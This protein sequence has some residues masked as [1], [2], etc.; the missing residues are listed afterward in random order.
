MA[1]PA[2]NFINAVGRAAGAAPAAAQAQFAALNDGGRMR[3]LG[4]VHDA[5]HANVGAPRFASDFSALGSMT[6]TYYGHNKYA[7]IDGR[8]VV[9]KTEGQTFADVHHLQTAFIESVVCVLAEDDFVGQ[10]M[11]P[12]VPIDSIVKEISIRVT[13]YNPG[14]ALQQ[15]DLGV[16]TMLTERTDVITGG[17]KRHAIGQVNGLWYGMTEEAMRAAA[18]R[19]AQLHGSFT[20]ARLMRCYDEIYRHASPES[21]YSMFGIRYG[22][23]DAVESYR[24]LHV[25]AARQ[26]GMCGKDVPTAGMA[27]RKFLEDGLAE[28]R[29]TLT[30]VLVPPSFMNFAIDAN[31]LSNPTQTSQSRIDSTYNGTSTPFDPV[32]RGVLV[33]VAKPIP[34]SSEV[35]MNPLIHTATVGLYNPIGMPSVVMACPPEYFRSPIMDIRVRCHENDCMVTIRY[36][37]VLKK[38]GL[39]SPPQNGHRV[40]GAGSTIGGAFIDALRARTELPN[41]VQMPRMGDLIRVNGLDSYFEALFPT[42]L[43]GVAVGGFFGT[44]RTRFTP[45]ALAQTL[46]NAAVAGVLDGR[47]RNSVTYDEFSQIP[48]DRVTLE[49]FELMHASDIPIPIPFVLF[50]PS[51]VSEMGH[52]IG[53]DLGHGSDDPGIGRAA[54]T[55]EITTTTTTLRQLATNHIVAHI[56]VVTTHPERLITAYNVVPVN[57][58]GGGAAAVADISSPATIAA[59]R[60]HVS[61]AGRSSRNTESGL[62]FSMLPIPVFS[63]ELDNIMASHVF[64]IGSHVGHADTQ[65]FANAA[66]LAPANVHKL[67]CAMA[68]VI[69]NRFY[70]RAGILSREA[71][72]RA[73]FSHADTFTLNTT[74]VIGLTVTPTVQAGGSIAFT[75]VIE[76]E[77]LGSSTA[78]GLLQ[79]FYSGRGITTVAPCYSMVSA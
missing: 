63:A 13:T 51:I 67:T 18:P 78:S 11:Y 12:L 47:G 44:K 38:S 17:L 68:P 59:F 24:R 74:G 48:L 40:L 21:V 76:D 22:A 15:P 56:A 42:V 30:G 25:A 19:M 52:V 79:N 26:F 34:I 39:F 20:S 33:G 58:V 49:M 31:A 64:T 73:N 50:R 55:P 54:Q 71:Q 77:I 62:P 16:P 75:D 36:L 3:A 35:R 7:H 5:G 10:H 9:Y 70:S 72:E 65:A 1:Q 37:D 23:Q 57:R 27:L 4:F 53:M 43:N 60:T 46:H 69:L 45:A 61:T 32:K 8:N 66:P 2:V 28:R 6:P 41:G 14:V 29:C